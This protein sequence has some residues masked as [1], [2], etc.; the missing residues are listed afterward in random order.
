[1]N[2][3]IEPT[4]RTQLRRLPKRG[5]FDRETIYKILDQG[6]VC[7]VGFTIGGRTFVIPTGYARIGDRLLIHGS[8]ASRMLQAM[9]EGIEVCA[10]VTLIDGLVLARSA[11]HHSVNYRSVVVFGAASLVSDED[12]KIKALHA[13]TEHIVPGR[14]QDVRPP[15]KSE[16][17]ATAVLSLPIQEASAKVRT[18]DPV[19]AEEDYA[20]DVWAGVIPL[21]LRADAPRSDARLKN[22]INPPS[23]VLNQTNETKTKNHEPKQ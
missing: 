5:V 7:H 13:F 6:F 10:T 4:D 14:W 15:N 3:Q 1:M 18:G 2:D 23:Y 19:D 8:S 12:E 9:S 20:L 16:L 17:A 22:G 21:K 11:F